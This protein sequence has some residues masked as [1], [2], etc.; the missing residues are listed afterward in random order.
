MLYFI[1][2]FQLFSIYAMNQIEQLEKKETANLEGYFLPGSWGE[3]FE[4]IMQQALKEAQQ[5]ENFNYQTFRSLTTKT[6][7]QWAKNVSYLEFIL[8]DNR[9]AIK[10]G[11]DV[12]KVKDT[13]SEKVIFESRNVYWLRVS[14]NG[15]YIAIRY[16]DEAGSLEIRRIC[17]GELIFSAFG[18]KIEPVVFYAN[19]K[20]AEIYYR[21]NMKQTIDL[22]SQQA[23]F[24]IPR[25]KKRKSKI[26]YKSGTIKVLDGRETQAKIIASW[27]RGKFP[28]KIG[29]KLIVVSKKSNVF[30][31]NEQ[32]L[33]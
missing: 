7:L 24:K 21:D 29:N 22:V 5:P 23:L 26:W 11:V 1:L 15:N 4:S 20:M 9:V 30:E 28:F 18:T 3:K 2:F 12:L 33:N 31:V 17:D 19:E 25:F 14:K 13:K 32:Q 27:K 8:D 6:L 16:W 10:E